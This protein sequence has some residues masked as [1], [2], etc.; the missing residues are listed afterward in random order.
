MSFIYKLIR[1][2]VVF[3]QEMASGETDNRSVWRDVKV[4]ARA[5]L[6]PSNLLDE[7]ERSGVK[8]NPDEVLAVTK[9]SSGK[10][11][12]LEKG[13]PKAGLEHVMSHAIDFASKGIKSYEIPDLL[14]KALSKGE[15]VGYQGRGTGRPI[16]EVVFNGQKQ[17]IAITVGNNGFIVGANPTSLP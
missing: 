12:W 7:L 6:K 3:L 17:R 1:F 8:Y 4:T 16:Y 11:V 5:N 10:L 13:S 9:T 2:R 14:M 15:V